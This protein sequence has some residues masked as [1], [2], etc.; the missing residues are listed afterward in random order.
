MLRTNHASPMAVRG[1]KRMDRSI[2][3]NRQILLHFLRGQFSWGELLV[4]GF[5]LA[6]ISLNSM[7]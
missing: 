7:L 4:D 1:N 3:G 2:T 5:Y 6:G